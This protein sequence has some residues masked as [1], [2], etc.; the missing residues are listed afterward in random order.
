ML[1]RNEGRYFYCRLVACWRHFLSLFLFYSFRSFAHL[2]DCYCYCYYSIV[3][4]CMPSSKRTRLFV[5]K[6]I[7]TSTYMHTYILKS[8]QCLYFVRSLHYVD[9]RT[10]ERTN[11]WNG[12]KRERESVCISNKRIN[13]Q[14]LSFCRQMPPEAMVDR[15]TES[16]HTASAYFSFVCPCSRLR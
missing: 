1:W 12:R 3:V 5:R 9:G 10:N 16:A 4:G 14:L 7:S 6:T 15:L 11:K 2:T 8:K 13:E